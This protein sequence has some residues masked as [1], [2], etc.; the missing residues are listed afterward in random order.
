[1]LTEL[2]STLEN[3]SSHAVMWT[4]HFKLTT[5]P[6]SGTPTPFSLKPYETIQGKFARVGNQQGFTADLP[7]AEYWLVKSNV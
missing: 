4:R 7:L 1:M 5:S 2:L 6:P 3:T